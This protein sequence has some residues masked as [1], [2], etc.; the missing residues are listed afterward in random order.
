M[1]IHKLILLAACLTVPAFSAPIQWTVAS[2]GNGHWYDLT[3]TLATWTGADAQATAAGG[4]L[5]TITS[6]AEDA[7][8]MANFTGRRWIGLTDVVTEGAYVWVTG[9]PFAYSNWRPG[10]PNNLGDED[11]TEINLVAIPQGWNDLPNAGP[12]FQP[13]LGIIEY[14]TDPTVPEPATISLLG[15]GLLVFLGLRARARRLG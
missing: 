15:A 14:N 2:G 9:E 1:S 6:A 11:Y 12:G 3:T 10:E 4:Y 5:A 13:T 7:F 8:I